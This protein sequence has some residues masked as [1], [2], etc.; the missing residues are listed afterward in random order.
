MVFWPWISIHANKFPTWW[1]YCQCI[2][3]GRRVS[4]A[5]SE[6]D[7]TVPKIISLDLDDDENRVRQKIKIKIKIWSNNQSFASEKRTIEMQ[8]RRCFD[9]P[10]IARNIALGIYLSI[11]INSRAKKNSRYRRR[12]WLAIHCYTWSLLLLQSNSWL[13]SLFWRHRSSPHESCGDND[14]EQLENL[15]AI[16]RCTE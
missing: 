13:I 2:F 15:L 5:L 6:G 7:I 1:F 9:D 10:N 11:I 4:T 3:L 14:N 16:V 8:V 12:G